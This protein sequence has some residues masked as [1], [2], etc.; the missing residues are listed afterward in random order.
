MSPQDTILQLGCGNSIL[1]E[2][3]YDVGYKNITNIDISPI[4]IEQMSE[5]SRD[6]RPR[7]SYLVGDVTQMESIADDNTVDV[8]LDKSTMDALLCG[9]QSFLMTA[10]MLYEVQR[11]LKVGGFYIMVSYGEPD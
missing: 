6:V 5:R 11:V 10:K 7:M 1:Q 3:M 8:V 2:E 9:D 4:V